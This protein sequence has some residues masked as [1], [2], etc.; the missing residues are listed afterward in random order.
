MWEQW[1]PVGWYC[2]LLQALKERWFDGIICIAL[3]C[4][5]LFSLFFFFLI[6]ILI[7]IFL[8]KLY[9]YNQIYALSVPFT[10]RKN[11]LIIL[12]LSK[13][14]KFNPIKLW[15]CECMKKKK[16]RLFLLTLNSQSFTPTCEE[17]NKYF[18]LINVYWELL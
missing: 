8:I 6:L 14:Y 3:L 13:R 1:G 2:F 9:G 11:L 16:L 10:Q 18:I 17:A 7:L 15:I 4:T 12:N 5:K